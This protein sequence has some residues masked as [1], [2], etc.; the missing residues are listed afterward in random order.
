MLIVACLV[1]NNL[2][3]MFGD[4]EFAKDT[5][6]GGDTEGYDDGVDDLAPEVPEPSEAR[7]K[8]AGEAHRESLLRYFQA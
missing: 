6:P 4:P 5:Q 1:L 3:V 8:A 2:A 7:S